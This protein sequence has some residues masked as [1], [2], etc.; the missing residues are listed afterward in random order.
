[1]KVTLI[2]HSDT[3]GGA[4]V[5]TYRLM[6]ALQNAGVDAQM[7]VSIKSGQNDHVTQIS[8]RHF[9]NYAFLMER[10]NIFTRNGFSRDNLFKISTATHG[11]PVSKHP[12]VTN[13][14]VIVLNWI[15]QGTLSLDEIDKIARLGKPIVWWMHD[16]WCL[17][18]ACHHALEC[19]HYKH[20]CGKCRFIGDGSD[21]NDLSHITWLKKNKIFTNPNIHYVAVS[22]WLAN[23]AKESELL[24]NADIS[25]IHH[26][27]PVDFFKTTPSNDIPAQLLGLP[28]NKKLILMGAARLDDP[29]K[30]VGYAIDAINLFVAQYP[31][32]AKDCELVLFGDIRDSSLLTRIKMPYHHIGRINDNKTLRHLYAMSSVVLSTSTYETLGAT[33]IEGQ[34]AGCVP[35]AFAHDGRGDIIDHKKNGYRAENKSTQD[36]ADGIAWAINNA[37]TRD[38]LHDSVRNRF[39]ND[40]IARQFIN[41]FN[42]LINK[43]S[44]GK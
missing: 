20:Q 11:L 35:V 39:S 37:P 4:S 27:F 25:V 15:N 3:L 24:R 16:M 7:L 23:K 12:L 1:M 14:D 28:N 29:I 40:V 42:C 26:A 18:G 9:R 22:N 32:E 13:A 8:S 33:L 41:L 10:I 21:K 2:N 43:E 19:D 36:I 30:G 17:T 34:A 31:N 6:Q 38:S 5:V 44:T